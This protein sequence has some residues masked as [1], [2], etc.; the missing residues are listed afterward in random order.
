MPEVVFTHL[1]RSSM[2]SSLSTCV[3]GIRMVVLISGHNYL[4]ALVYWLDSSVSFLENCSS[5]TRPLRIR[6]ETLSKVPEQKTR[7]M[8]APPFRVI[9]IISFLSPRHTCHLS[10]PPPD[11]AQRKQPQP[12]GKQELHCQP[13][14]KF[15]YFFQQWREPAQSGAVTVAATPAKHEVGWHGHRRSWCWVWSPW[16]R[17]LS[18]SC[19]RAR[20][21]Q[22]EA[23]WLPRSL[24]LSSFSHS[25]DVFYT[26]SLKASKEKKD[27][28]CGQWGCRRSAITW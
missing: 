8:L 23:G 1:Q 4:K 3:A 24:Q 7:H 11:T 5:L 12:Q 27:R 22:C 16:W 25:P 14:L 20:S 28:R 17:E 2:Y 18:W 21:R 13:S 26:H 10:F 19:S 6:S 9:S 15:S